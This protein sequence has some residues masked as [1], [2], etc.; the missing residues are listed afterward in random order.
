MC[1]AHSYVLRPSEATLVQIKYGS[2][3]VKKDTEEVLCTSSAMRNCRNFCGART[4]HQ[5]AHTG[6]LGRQFGSGYR[7]KTPHDEVDDWTRSSIPMRI[8]STRVKLTFSGRTTI[9]SRMPTSIEGSCPSNSF[10]LN[11]DI[12]NVRKPTRK[13]THQLAL[14]W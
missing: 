4:R 14:G 7:P 11:N 5:Q 2:I 8:F 9:M 13:V 12:F 10:T 3:S 6:E 1:G